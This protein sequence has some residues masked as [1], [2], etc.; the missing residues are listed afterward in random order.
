MNT[1]GGGPSQRDVVLTVRLQSSEIH[2]VNH[3]NLVN[4]ID[5]IRRITHDL[6][7]FA[8]KNITGVRPVQRATRKRDAAS[9]ATSATAP[10][11]DW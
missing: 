8:S 6:Q 3:D 11:E 1:D 5:R 2:H 9:P 10:L 4:P 7:D